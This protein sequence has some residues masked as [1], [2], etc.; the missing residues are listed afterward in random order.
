MCEQE[1]PKSFRISAKK[2]LLTYSQI[3]KETGFTK[4]NLLE[5]LQL[6]LGYFSY[7][8]SEEAHSDGGM[9]FHVLLIRDQKFN[10]KS[11]FLLDLEIDGRVA[12]GNYKPVNSMGRTVHYVCKDKRYI[13][14]LENL[15]DGKILD[16]KEFLLQRAKIVGTQ[17]ALNEFANK[18]PKR[19]LSSICSLEKNLQ[20]M[21]NLQKATKGDLLETPFTLENFHMEGVLKLWALNPKLLALF[22]VGDSGIGKTQFAKAFCIEHQWKTLLVS[23]KEDFKR[24][25]TSYEAVIIDDANFNDFTDTQKLSLIDNSVEK[26]IRVMYQ[27]VTKKEGVVMMILMNHK[28]YKDIHHLLQEKALARR[29]LICEPQRPFMINVNINIQNNHHGDVHHGDVNHYHS[30]NDFEKHQLHEETRIEGNRKRCAAI[31]EKALQ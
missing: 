5:Q 17:A 11:H 14:N 6:K 12:H 19:A 16:D 4:N 3:S 18:Y 20:K 31:Y 15:Q 2:I 9:H 1:Q 7:I 24:I 13:T 25:D 23:H 10:I 30:L 29:F 8:I 21:L 22:L 28:Q 26:T 27:T